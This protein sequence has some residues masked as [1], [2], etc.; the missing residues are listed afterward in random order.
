MPTRDY[1]ETLLERAQDEPEFREELLKGAVRCMFNGE[2]RI[3][4]LRLHN[5]IYAA[6]GF[7]ELSRKTGRRL[8]DLERIF[9]RNGNPRADELLSIIAALAEH[10]DIELD[11]QVLQRSRA[12]QLVAA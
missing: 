9:S 12:E 8:E 11:V 10:E 3:G 6:I 4:R 2:P 1:R 5:Y 7:D